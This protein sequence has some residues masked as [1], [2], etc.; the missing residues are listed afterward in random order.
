MQLNI[1]SFLFSGNTF[2][3]A[4]ENRNTTAAQ[5]LQICDSMNTN[6]VLKQKIKKRRRGETRQ[7]QTGKI[8][9]FY[10]NIKYFLITK[11]Y[12]HP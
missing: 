10:E 2:D 6:K 7:W 4:L 12:L 9:M 11:L 8:F 1:F 3:S 5:Y